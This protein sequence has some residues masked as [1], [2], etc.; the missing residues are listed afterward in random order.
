MTAGVVCGPPGAKMSAMAQPSGVSIVVPAYREALNIQPL[1]ERIGAALGP[2]HR[3]Y[4]ILLVD[5]DSRDGTEEAA[6]RLSASHPVRLLVRKGE[7]GL[8]GAVVH[9]LREA[10]FD[11]LVVMDA[12]L[13]HPPEAIPTMVEALEG[14]AVEF[15]IGTRY[16]GAGSVAR[17]WPVW[18]RLGSRAA[19]M[20]ARPV[21]R[22]SDPM[23]GFFALRRPVWNRAESEVDPIG[24]KIALELLVKSRCRNVREVSITFAARQAGESKADLRVMLRFVQHLWRLY[25]FRFPRW[26]RVCVVSAIALIVVVVIVACRLWL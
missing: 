5:D 18:R 14:E 12:D 19:T 8:S 2:T 23:S 7:R 20:L 13:Q 10:A 25:R 11:C 17:D 15:V 26:T 6:V 22:V 16:A 1:V 24:Y 9:G 21:A 3:P 4:E